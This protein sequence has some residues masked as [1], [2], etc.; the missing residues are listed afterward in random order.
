MKKTGK[1]RLVFAYALLIT[2]FAVVIGLFIFEIIRNGGAIE[3]TDAV[4][5]VF[6]TAGLIITLVRVI[7]KTGSTFSLG[8]YEALYS[9]HIGTAFSTP[10]K[11]RQKRSLLQAI[12]SYNQNDYNAAIKRL[13]ALRSECRTS[14]E[15]KAVLLFLALSYSDAGMVDEAIAIYNE[16][17]ELCPEDSTAWSNLGLLYKRTGKYDDAVYCFESAIRYDEN[18][19]YAWNNLANVYVST[20]NWQKVISPAQRS[21]AIKADMHQAETALTVAYYAMGE[22]EQSKKYFDL[23]VLHGADAANL[24]LLIRSMAHSTV[25]FG[26]TY[27]IGEKIIQ[28][29]GHLQRDTALPMVEVRLPA[30]DDGNRSRLGGAPV[31][32]VVPV[33]SRGKPMKLLAALWCSEVRGVPYFPSR[34]VLRFYVADN[35][36]YGADFRNPAVQTDFRVLYDENEEAFNTELRNDP[37]VSKEFPVQHVLPVRLTPAMSSVRSSDYR[38]K[39]HADASLHKAGVEGGIESLSEEEYE[40]IY[41]QNAYAGHRIGG[42]PCFEQADPRSDMRFQKY[43]TLLLQI[44]SHTASDGKG[45]QRDLVMFGDDGGCQF[46]IP[47]ERLIARDFSDVMYWW[48]CC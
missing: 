25:A 45:S 43:D 41:N 1:G 9:K 24:T 5:F 14:Q 15:Q 31:E 46:F 3:S 21:L 44:V 20:N 10:D 18:N 11:K 4:K 34:G 16:L 47:R 27:R 23:A 33:D 12:A 22:Y 40:Y 13:S 7:A 2:A 19:A 39:E 30:P 35:D 42:Y 36:V 26:V 38:F 28:A 8:K 17:V 29:V 6:V 37:S 32:A 48:D